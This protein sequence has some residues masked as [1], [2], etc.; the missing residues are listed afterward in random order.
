MPDGTDGELVVTLLTNYTMP[1]LRYRIGDRGA[2]A[3]EGTGWQGDAARVLLRVTG[4]TVDAFKLSDGTVIDGRWFINLLYDREWL[5]HFQVIQRDYADVLFRIVRCGEQP[6]DAERR[7]IDGARAVMGSQ[8][9]VE[10]EYCDEIEPGSSGKY[11]YT[12]S[13]VS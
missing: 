9:R 2:L 7:I 1:L 13:E 6:A 3:P 11:R 10:F 4:R 8:C 12:M 5:T